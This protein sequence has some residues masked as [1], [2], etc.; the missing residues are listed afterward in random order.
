VI[1][2]PKAR[3]LKNEPRAIEALLEIYGQI[4]PTLLA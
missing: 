2:G 4:P 3:L 1:G